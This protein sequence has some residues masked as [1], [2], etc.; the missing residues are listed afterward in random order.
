[1]NNLNLYKYALVWLL[2]IS[3]VFLSIFGVLIYFSFNVNFY[4]N[5]SGQS[6]VTS[7]NISDLESVYSFLQNKE[8][9]NNNF[10]SLELSHLQDVKKIFSIA[11]YVFWISIAIFISIALFFI[12]SSKYKPIFR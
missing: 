5:H 10:G 11:H 8:A 4:K 9:L 2:S 6:Q 1:M 7:T 12:L 3:F